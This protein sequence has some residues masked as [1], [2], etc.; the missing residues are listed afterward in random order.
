MDTAPGRGSERCC[1]TRMP[2][3]AH[4]SFTMGMSSAIGREEGWSRV[5]ISQEKGR[6]KKTAYVDPIVMIVDDDGDA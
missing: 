5:Y 1:F 2:L 4:V 6:V 3:R